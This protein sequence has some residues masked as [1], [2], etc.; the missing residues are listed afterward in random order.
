MEE[1]AAIARLKQ[2]HP[3]GLKPLVDLYQVQAVRAAQLITRNRSLAEDVVQSAFV[4]AFE[5]IGQFDERRPFGP[6]FLRSVINGAIKAVGKHRRQIS[7][8]AILES[9]SAASQLLV[10][11]CP[12]PDEQAEVAE[13]HALV[14]AALEMLSPEQRAAVVLRYYL[15]WT[16]AEIAEQS[17]IPRGT[18]R[19]RLH[20]A[21]QRLRELLLA[22]HLSNEDAPG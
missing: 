13:R 14:L 9:N 5:R 22:F 11:S 15:G 7:L 4:R 16:D 21:R 18:I 12:G 2:G 8:D 6:W 20:A 1:R 3:D 17:H 10:D 19:W